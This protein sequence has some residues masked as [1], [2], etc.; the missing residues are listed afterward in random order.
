VNAVLPVGRT[1]L[2][3]LWG[4]FGEAEPGQGQG[5][6]PATGSRRSRSSPAPPRRGRPLGR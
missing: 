6:G 2:K 1:Y 4:A 5:Q 3:P